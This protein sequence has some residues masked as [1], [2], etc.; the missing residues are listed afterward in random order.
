MWSIGELK[1]NAKEALKR[2]Y[3]L[4]FA[5]CLISSIISG[6]LSGASSSM[7]SGATSSSAVN[8]GSGALGSFD[9]SAIAAA[10]AAL[11][12]LIFVIL[13]IG[14]VVSY[15]Y[16]VFVSGPVTVGMKRFFMLGRAFDNLNVGMLFSQFRKGRYMGTVKVIW[17]KTW[18]IFLWYC[19]F[20]V[21]GIIK[22]Y[23]YYLV[24]YIVAENPDIDPKRALELSKQMTDGEKWNIFCAQ[25]SFIGWWIL[26]VIICC[27]IGCLFVQPYYEATMAEL[28]TVLRQK[29][30]DNG[31]TNSSELLG[32]DPAE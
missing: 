31:I 32:F 30:F 14:T 17:A 15:A 25:L 28:Y 10:V 13:I 2:F 23:E 29:A 5:V 3:W 8:S 24:D 1:E 12:M 27:G 18:R 7:N 22:T 16:Q 6:L 20:I 9:S 26:G 19:V 4:G 11:G 21:P